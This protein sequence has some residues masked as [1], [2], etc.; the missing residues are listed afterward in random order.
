M[1]QPW[2]SVLLIIA[3]SSLAACD[4]TALPP[5]PSTGGSGGGAETCSTEQTALPHSVDS[6][7]AAAALQELANAFPLDPPRG[8]HLSWFVLRQSPAIASYRYT[9]RVYGALAVGDLDGDD[10]IDLVASGNAT[11]LGVFLNPG[12]FEFNEATAASG[13]SDVYS[14]SLALGD[15]DN[16]GDRDLVTTERLKLRIFANDGA[17]HFSA[18]GEY[19][20]PEVPADHLLLVDVDNDGLLDIFGGYPP[21]LS[22]F[23]RSGPNRLF[24][25]SGELTFADISDELELPVDGKS[26][27]SGACDLDGDDDQDIVVAND[28][29]VIDFGERSETR[30]EVDFPFNGALFNQ[31]AGQRFVDEAE[32]LGLQ[33]PYSS[34]GVLFEDLDRDGTFEIFITDFGANKLMQ[35]G[36]NG[37]YRDVAADFGLDPAHRINDRCDETLETADCLLVSWG[38]AFRDFDLDGVDELLVAN[39]EADTGFGQ[40]MQLFKKDG[41]R[42][43]EYSLGIPSV[44]TH[45]LVTADFDADGDLDF[46]TST[47]GQ[48][49]LVFENIVGDRCEGNWLGVRLRSRQEGEGIGATV[50][51]EQEDGQRQMR[52]ITSGGVPHGSVLSETH[53]GLGDHTAQRVTVHWPSGADSVLENPPE[54]SRVVIREGD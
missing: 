17:G 22:A 52:L 32:S 16:D 49:L 23:D 4:G 44:P 3:S 31:S 45:A 34:M 51:V 24:R 50:T 46:A 1:T 12:D 37:R 9:S 27:A 38:A 53:F 2:R 19:E 48:G 33:G 14:H 26:W 25:N 30:S 43:R 36:A 5:P 40:P 39:H 35:R 28:G 15:L 13:L 18:S 47:V 41:D 21:G 20:A 54:R 6:A 29:N 7:R 11:P 8:P 42:Y 10:T